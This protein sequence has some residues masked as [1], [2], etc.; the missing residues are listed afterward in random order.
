M[1]TLTDAHVESI[2]NAP[3]YIAAWQRT[4]EIGQAHQVRLLYIRRILGPQA[5]GGYFSCTR[6]AVNDKFIDAW[7]QAQTN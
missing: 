1:F 6:K 7:K 2:T 5:T 3:T 4:G